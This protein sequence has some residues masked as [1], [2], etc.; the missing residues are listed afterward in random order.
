MRYFYFTG[1]T[2]L[3]DVAQIVRSEC[4]ARVWPWVGSATKLLGQCC[5]IFIDLNFLQHAADFGDTWL[6]VQP[7]LTSFGEQL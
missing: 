5:R 3:S 6:Q 7:P 1:N 4:R 2:L